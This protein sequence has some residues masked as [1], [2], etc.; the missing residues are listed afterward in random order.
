MSSPATT[1]MNQIDLEKQQRPFSVVTSNET[2]FDSRRAS[3]ADEA[4]VVQGSDS[5]DAIDA[6]GEERIPEKQEHSPY[7]VKWDGPD[8]PE[9]PKVSQPAFGP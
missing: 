3:V 8:D 4:T 9:N 5:D 6:P 2:P 1:P 7:L